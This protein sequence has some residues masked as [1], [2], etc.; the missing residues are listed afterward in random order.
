M[1]DPYE[2]LGL[3]RGASNDEVKSAYRRL[4]RKYHPDA[5]VN[6]PNKEEAEE[7]FKEIQQAYKAIMD[8]EADAPGGAYGAG[9]YNG[10]YGGGYNGSYG[11]SYRNTSQNGRT[12]YDESD[13][14]GGFYSGFGPFGGFGG[15]SRRE[16]EYNANDQESRY[17]QAARNYLRSGSYEEARNVLNQIENHNAKWHYYSGVCNAGLGNQIRALE[18][19]QRAMQMEPDNMEYKQA[20]EQIKSGSKW[21]MDQGQGYGMDMSGRDMTKCCNTVCTICL[22]T[23]CCGN[24][25]NPFGCFYMGTPG[26]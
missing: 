10:S 24:I 19:L 26:R 23:S 9:G 3:K 8:G 15:Y 22:L 17:F 12:T 5:N 18:M 25:C 7:K 21:Y 20:Y 6:N 11:G 14:F 13:P 2:V 16:E 1:K 4:S